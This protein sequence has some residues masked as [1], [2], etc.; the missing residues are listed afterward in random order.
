[1][2]G[3][4]KTVDLSLV[5]H[6]NQ[7]K[8]TLVRTLLRQEVGE[9]L[10]QAHV[11]DENTPH[12]LIATGQSKLILWDTPGF[13]DSA[14]LL[15]RL[16][17]H[18]NPLGWFQGQ[19]IDRLT[20][21]SMW[22]GQQAVTNVREDAD[23]V[24]YLVNGSESPDAAGYL[25]PEL[26]IL[27]W[28]GKP[29]IVV[30]NQTGPP[31]DTADAR[32]E[33]ERWRAWAA[34]HML[35]RDVLSLDAFTRCWVQEGVLFERVVDSLAED[36][37]DTMRGL[38]EAWHMRNAEIFGDAIGS[39]AT[40][41]TSAATDRV[42]LERNDMAERRN[43]SSRLREDV[44][45]RMR[46]LSH[47][48]IRLHGLEGRSERDIETD[49]ADLVLPQRAADDKRSAIWG[50]VLGGLGG[51]LL[52][53]VLSGGL[54]LGGGMIG[55][56]LVGLLGGFGYSRTQKVLK[57][58]EQPALTWTP[59]FLKRLTAEALLLYLAIAHYGR[60]RG[61]YRDLEQPKHWNDAIETALSGRMEGLASAAR[62]GGQVFEDLLR[63]VLEDVLRRLYP[64]AGPAL[65]RASRSSGS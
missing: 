19:V 41:L 52:A 39:V 8:T 11:T 64:E 30:L 32:A 49:I 4:S 23:L 42:P 18:D 35:I 13:G 20:D 3:T 28:I 2:S 22:C 47:A 5:S 15:K 65:A 57:G 1:L 48:V 9:V 45:R 56:T 29:V 51:G 60:G 12:E 53:D 40:F 21:R 16:E 38:V 43:A 10:D 34:R 61:D 26:E 58:E 62:D 24:L 6:T 44:R 59:E 36:A 25:G 46:E 33:V 31:L 50:G 55:G 37:R 54:T 17:G 27:K 14:R 63:T 7:G